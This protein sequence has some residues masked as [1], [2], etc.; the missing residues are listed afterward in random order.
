M[1][2][3]N[4]GVTIRWRMTSPIPSS[5]RAMWDDLLIPSF[6]AEVLRPDAVELVV[7]DQYEAVAGEYSVHSPVVANPTETADDYRAMKSD[8][9]MAVAKTIDLPDDQIAVVVGSAITRLGSEQAWRALFHETKHVRLHQKTTS[10]WGVHRR[11]T[12]NLP[13]DLSYGFVWIAEIAID[14]F[15]CERAVYEDFD[16]YNLEDGSLYW[17]TLR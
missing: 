16:F 3:A 8:G 11:T 6:T 14:E 7:T 4:K 13:D 1:P 10:A 12:F 5:D 17:E 9:A 15:R 2:K